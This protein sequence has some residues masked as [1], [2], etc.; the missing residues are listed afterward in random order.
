M[1]A[2]SGG[3]AGGPRGIAVVPCRCGRR[4]PALRAPPA[5]CPLCLLPPQLLQRLQPTVYLPLLNTET[6]GEGPL[7]Q[8]MSVADVPVAGLQAKLAGAGLSAVRVADPPT[9]GQPLVL[10]DR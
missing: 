6:E 2:V 5:P 3:R 8:L 1:R 7:A 4:H 10:A 9:P